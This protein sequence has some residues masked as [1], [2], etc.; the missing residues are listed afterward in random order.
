M[1]QPEID[2]KKDYTSK[3]YSA[4]KDNL[5]GFDK[6]EEQFR[7]SLANE[8]EYINKVHKALSENLSGFNKTPQELSGLLNVKKKESSKS[9]SQNQNVASEQKNGLLD[10]LG[11]E[12][13]QIF[14]DPMF[15]M[16]NK[17]KAVKPKDN[18]SLYPEG[19]AAWNHEKLKQADPEYTRIWKDY[20]R[21]TTLP[22]EE[23]DRIT[24]E[25]NAKA[26]ESST[27][28]KIKTGGRVMWNTMTRFVPALQV[29]IDPLNKEKAQALKEFEQQNLQAKKNNNPTIDFSLDDI[30]KRAREIAINN[31]IKSE[32]DS[33]K[34]DF[35]SFTDTY[36]GN[37]EKRKKL[38]LYQAGEQATLN[39]NDKN[40]L[41]E[42]DFF[43]EAIEA[44]QAKI[45]DLQ[46][47]AADYV[48]NNQPIP[49]SLYNDYQ[50]DF[51]QY[52]E[53]INDAEKS[54]N[55]YVNNYENL[56][57]AIENLD[58]LKRDH[59]SLGNFFANLGVSVIALSK[60]FE[61]FEG[62]LNETFG[63]PLDKEQMRAETKK[64][65]AELNK[66]SE[67][68]SEKY[69]RPISVDDI[70]TLDDFG[71]W[72]ANTVVAQQVP[73]YALTATG[74]PGVAA[75]GMSSTGQEYNQMQEDIDNGAQ[76]TDTQKALIPFAYGITETASAAVDAM[77]VKNAGRVVRAATEPERKMI[78]S[79]MWSQLKEGVLK[80]TKEI[81]KNVV[82][83]GLDEAGTQVAQN[84]L[85]RYALDKKEVN[86]FDGVKDAAA[87]GA[88]MGGTLPM[89][90]SIAAELIKPFTQ[91]KQLQKISTTIAGL[92]NKLTDTSLKE[93]TRLVMQN[94][95]D[96]AKANQRMLMM[97][98][99][100][101]VEG[102]DNTTFTALL[103]IEKQQAGLKQ[104]ARDIQTDPDIDE[105]TRK[106]LLDGLKEDF[107]SSEQRRTGLLNGTVKTEI[108]EETTPQAKQEAQPQAEAQAQ[109]K[110]V[111]D[112]QSNNGQIKNTTEN[113]N[114]D[115]NQTEIPNPNQ[116]KN[117]GTP[118]GNIT[119]DGSL[120]AGTGIME[121]NTSSGEGAQQ[122]SAQPAPDTRTGEATVAVDTNK[123]Y[124][125]APNGKQYKA[126]KESGRITITDD[127]GKEPSAPTRRKVEE[128]YAD[129]FDFT[130]GEKAP[131]V[132]DNIDINS[133]I[134]NSSQNPVEV[135]QAISDIDN[136]ALINE[137]IGY[138]DR[139]IAE[140]IGK[141][142]RN[143]FIENDDANNINRSLAKS[144]FNSNGKSIDVLAQEMSDTA[145]IEITP[146]D[147]VDFIKENPNGPD[148]LFSR[149]KRE[150]R[151]P[152][153]NRFTELTGLP[154]NEKYLA[155]AVEQQN[156]KDNFAT[157]LDFMSDEE[158]TL[159]DKEY[160]LLND[161]DNGKQE[162][163]TQ[164]A[165]T[166]GTDSQNNETGS[167]G[168]GLQSVRGAENSGEKTTG[169]REVNP[170]KKQN[171][172]LLF[173]IAPSTKNRVIKEVLGP[174]TKKEAAIINEKTGL[175]ID[176]EYEYV[177]DNSAI[178]HILKKHG[179]PEKESKQGQLA[180]T[181]A[182]FELLPEILSSYDDIEYSGKNERGLD[183]LKYTKTFKDG[184]TYVIEEVR[185]GRKELALNTMYKRRSP[186]GFVQK[187]SPPLTS[188][189][190][191]GISSKDTKIQNKTD[192]DTDQATV[193]N[194][195]KNLITERIKPDRRVP[196]DTPKK[197]NQIIANAA[198]ALKATVIYG[199]SGRAGAIGTYSSRNT[200]T[201]I[202][203]PG[204]IDTTAHELG[205][206][207]D[208]RHN[209]L[210]T[211]PADMELSAIRELQWFSERGGSNPPAGLSAAKKAEY[212]E[213]EGLAEFIRAYIANPA[214][215][216]IMGPTLFEHFEKSI[217]EN[218]LKAVKQLSDDFI[219]FANAE[220]GDQIMA[221]VEDTNLKDKEGFKK[222]L[223][224]FKTKEGQFNVNPFDKIKAHWINSL[225]I[226]FKAYDFLTKLSGMKNLLPEQNFE[227]LS[228]L[229]AGVNGK[230][231]SIIDRGMIDAKNNVLNDKEGNPMNF[232][233][234]LTPLDST[235]KETLKEDIEDTVKFLIAERTVEYAKKF[236]R[237]DQLTG[238]G[239]GVQSDLDVA[240]GYLN[241]FEA[242]KENNK[243]KYNRIKEAAKRYRD[244][245]D[246]GLRYARD[247]GRISKEQYQTI[248]DNNQYYVSMARVQENAPM[249]EEV[250][251]FNDLGGGITSVKDVFKRAKGGTGIIQNP[252][253]SLLQNTVN[254]IRESDRNA[255]MQ[256]FIEPMQQLRAMGDGTP[257][258][259][260]QIARPAHTGDKNVKTIY[261]DGEQQRWQFS[262]DIYDALT[263][264]ESE[265]K[266]QILDILSKPGDL[267]RFTVTNFPTFA[268][269][270]AVRDTSSRLIVSRTNSGFKDMVHSAT[271]KELFELYGGGQAGFYL[272]DKEGYKQKMKE[273]IAEITKN[274]GIVLDPKAM[275]RGYR[276]LLEKG[277]NINRIAEFKSA[278]RKAKKE[279][280]DDYNARLYAAYQ[281]RDLMDFAVA[282]HTV[283][284][285]NRII[286]FLNAGIQGLNRTYKG[287][288]EDPAGFAVR[289]ALY[290]VL[291]TIAFR[292]LISTMGDDDEYEELPS[293]QRDMF[294]NFK[295][296]FTGDVW[297]SIPKPFEQGMVSSTVDRGIS[298]LKGYDN[299]WEGFNGS[300]AK[301]LVPVEESSLLG[302]LR[303][304]FE[305][306]SNYNYFTE[307][308]I[309]PAWEEGKMME[310]RK[311]RND[312]SRIGLNVADGFNAAG[313]TVDPRNVDHLLRGYG[314]YYAD[315]AL[316]LSDIGRE[317]SRNKFGVSKTGFAK[318]VPINNSRSV[319][320]VYELAT[321]LGKWQ[322]TRIKH[323]RG[324]IEN[325]Y[326]EDDAAKRKKLSKEIYDYAKDLRVYFEKE[327]QK[328]KEKP[329][330]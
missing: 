284:K 40:L 217:S 113:A 108:N 276:K 305:V 179:N 324:M 208:D 146:Q 39:E 11:T 171:I 197:L 267:I 9:S 31:R 118:Q 165:T 136:D 260:S 325:F 107:D 96:K 68:V 3:V 154:A 191:P 258:D 274:G 13:N 327:K 290:T 186:G 215:S 231:N 249:Q 216:K 158:L 69:M 285:L 183:I 251:I 36:E 292:L 110:E 288:K 102:M 253:I 90:G 229:F 50:Q 277:E 268:L 323:L 1:L 185:T 220:Y 72:I 205:H 48:R 224:R 53:L 265:A 257:L 129:D 140:Q 225:G 76:Y 24:E 33:R 282:G 6:T 173:D 195:N 55:A 150:A 94:Q 156:F 243:E 237:T 206:M 71:K 252:Y 269:R 32:Q 64:S 174:V 12:N 218:D 93:G 264:L 10:I 35:L 2:K 166:P 233:W 18:S 85:D 4:L 193:Q 83:E 310:L 120:R 145:G 239:G 98:I 302:G 135:A 66:L 196:K 328:V 176:E 25:V 61:G 45:T 281:A 219:D 103:A 279:G 65:V 329:A 201:R 301:T 21:A 271:D 314:T 234:L 87:A 299:A 182:D 75:I 227:I 313:W 30:D 262:Q 56:G 315:W 175:S 63:D 49:E 143:S 130:A 15:Y 254:I 62:Y 28:S 235:S 286:P 157:S 248:K 232:E 126:V 316:S 167:G 153:E 144:Y 192:K 47:K 84:L 112:A 307:R 287:A 99:A 149:V 259:F 189:T 320:A 326:D 187:N 17:P 210:G 198:K 27:W 228:R 293:Y 214:Q 29:S 60:G 330:N 73:I 246:A 58:V 19:S 82:I 79:G 309:V 297:I 238:I 212:I 202:K 199:K 148:S 44:K 111:T 295:T 141:V 169:E 308:H 203:N 244:F 67:K 95:L 300:L 121:Q 151:G 89:G 46:K 270:N 105:G 242:L 22:Q 321:E 163:T 26:D 226:S 123:T 86:V 294:W 311:G 180:V 318:D 78:A 152:L 194:R 42:Q 133:H 106:Y 7:Q 188:E 172:S 119:A 278:Y 178:N 241:Q 115:G 134:A 52:K 51:E 266:S 128:L 296:P 97:D 91:D 127:N 5:A 283:R 147:I 124:Q 81:G 41:K 16:K 177:V 159:L 142:K 306:A 164:P 38:Y 247:K 59:N 116:I 280:L 317:D 240:M 162:K 34:R 211:I 289:T 272:V 207:L 57:S 37:D 20:K 88:I 184:T 181:K 256:S 250:P 221:N 213:R 122:E 77:I 161:S 131:E 14:G 230:T 291:P 273:G 114:T 275:W 170:D 209:I 304:F 160:S 137:N 117:E 43:R 132:N 23:I 101:K 298:Q 54:Y 223:E 303:P 138:K 190:T 168:S 322:N 70:N 8:P 155:K 125:L 222:Y 74:A 204:D 245:A 255:V 80:S 92:E 236:F 200:L 312:A 319:Q 100:K 109:S 139:I 261:V 263:G 104:Q